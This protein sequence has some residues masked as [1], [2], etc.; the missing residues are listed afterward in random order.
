M[1]RSPIKCTNCG[2]SFLRSLGRI[3]EGLKKKWR[4][5][6]SLA[7]LGNYRNKQ[8]IF[9]CA[10]PHCSNSVKRRPSDISSS[11]ICFC[12]RSCAAIF[13]N[14][15]SRKRRPKIRLCP[16]CG[17]EFTGRKKYCSNKCITHPPIIDKEKI[18]EEIQKFYRQNGRIPL[19]REFYHYKAARTRFG[20]WNKAIGTSGFEPNP[21]KFAMKC[22]A[23]D[24]HK[25]DS[26]AEKIIDD[27]LY[28]RNI[29]HETKVPY[30]K[31]GMTA[32]FKIN[33]I[34][35]EFLGLYGAL[36]KYDGILS[37]KEKLWKERNLKV[38]KIFPRDLFP[39]NRLGE[40]LKF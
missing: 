39:E 19:K 24:G 37:K 23:N 38:I 29:P 25:C 13:N 28:I 12:S 16:T 31:N 27:W 11:G 8:K 35:V 40:I 3:N 26:L 14:S 34:F 4:S 36:D 20:N 1:T 33:G 30:N 2:K 6:C 15:K 5:F 18:I 10:N 32:D 17:K 9:H 21:V 22:I 7:C